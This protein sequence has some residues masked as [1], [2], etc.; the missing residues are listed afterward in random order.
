MRNEAI[1]LEEKRLERISEISDYQSVH[2]ED[3]RIFPG[4]IRRPEAGQD[5]GC[6]RGGRGSR[7]EIKD[8]YPSELICNDISPKALQTMNKLGLKTVS[9]D[10]DDNSSTFP[11]P[12]N[13]F[14][15]VIALATIKHL[16]HIDHFV[17]EIHRVL[18]KDGFFYISAPNYYGDH[19]SI[20]FSTQWQDL[21]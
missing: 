18:K 15:A 5:S 20:A 21:S 12:D 8:H 6:G 2:D 14:D 9:F 16:V 19:L 17:Q 3:T 13:H 7:Q 4:G 11:F 1:A 10:I